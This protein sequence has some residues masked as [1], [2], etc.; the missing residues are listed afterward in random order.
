MDNSYIYLVPMALLGI[1]ANGIAIAPQ[2]FV[3]LAYVTKL[4]YQKIAL[5]ANAFFSS[6]I[7][8]YFSVVVFSKLVDQKDP[9]PSYTIELTELLKSKFIIIAI[10]ILFCIAII[11]RMKFSVKLMAIMSLI[12][13][14][15]GFVFWGK[16]GILSL[17]F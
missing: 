3:I 15:S 10:S 1:I 6:L 9:C 12:S 16:L 17:E 7:G 2:C 13:I 14:I 11:R 4:K 5:C 8:G